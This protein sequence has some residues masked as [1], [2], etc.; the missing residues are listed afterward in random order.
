[1]TSTTGAAAIFFLEIGAR[2]GAG[3]GAGRG[4]GRGGGRVER[5]GGRGRKSVYLVHRLLLAT[6]HQGPMEQE[7]P[8]KKAGFLTK[9]YWV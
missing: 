7:E 4:V 3:S 1:M 9:L 6:E 8:P 5:R 2:R